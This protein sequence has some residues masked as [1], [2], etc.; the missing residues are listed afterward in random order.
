MTTTENATIQAVRSTVAGDPAGIEVARV[1]PPVAG[2]DE[3]LV[4]VHAASITRTELE[5]FPDRVPSIPSF[6]ISGVVE[7]TG[8]EVFALLPFDR[9]GGARELV[10]V[11]ASALAPKP[12][13][14]SHVEAAALPMPGLT[15]WQALFDHGRLA[16][17]E[18]VLILGGAG[19]VGSVAVQLAKWRGAHVVATASPGNIETVRSLGADEVIDHTAQDFTQIEPVAVVF[20]TAGG[21]NLTRAPAVLATGGR[22][23]SVAEEGSGVYF[24]VEPNGAQLAEIG[25]LVDAGKVKPLVDATF[26]LADARAAFERSLAGSRKGKI[27]LEVTA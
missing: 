7:D 18:R 17:G 6:E 8:E 21:E 15:A 12:A 16:P 4:R 9:D 23:V 2:P 14:L 5:W 24:I 13:A 3:K 10:S 26:P 25:K 22:L 1:A 20:D 27:V 11:P 19:G